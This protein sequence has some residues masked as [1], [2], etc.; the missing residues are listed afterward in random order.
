MRLVVPPPDR[1]AVRIAFAT[2]DRLRV[3]QHFGVAVG[4]A[5]FEITP[6]QARLS[7]WVTDPAPLANTHDEDRLTRKID[8]LT[9]CSAVYCVAVGASAVQRLLTAGIQP[10]K[11]APGTP[12]SD[13][14]AALQKQLVENPPA[15]L[16]RALR[17]RDR[18]SAAQRI[19]ALADE[20][21]DE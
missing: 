8:A 16:L 11:V 1:E 7:E 9:G 19:A 15:W 3:D 14:L 18:S 17:H 20:E 2:S 21:W 5:I 4:F 13:L 10:L 6:T 12:I